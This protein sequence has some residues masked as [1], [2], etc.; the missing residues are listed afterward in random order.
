MGKLFSKLGA[1]AT[2]SG[3]PDDSRAPGRRGWKLTAGPAALDAVGSALIDGFRH[4]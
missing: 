2:I 4:V 3:G 1:E